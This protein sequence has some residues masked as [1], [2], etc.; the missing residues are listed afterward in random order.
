[1]MVLDYNTL[2]IQY[3]CYVYLQYTK[4]FPPVPV[5]RLKK[6]APSQM[7]HILATFISLYKAGKHGPWY[8]RCGIRKQ[9]ANM[10][11][12]GAVAAVRHLIT[13]IIRVMMI[14]VSPLHT[15]TT[16]SFSENRAETIISYIKKIGV[17]LQKIK[18]F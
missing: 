6:V 10:D 9:H 12:V 16:H 18:A 8:R 1:M 11:F 3:T 2:Y 5:S 4:Q 17:I 14:F 13:I 7:L 15:Q